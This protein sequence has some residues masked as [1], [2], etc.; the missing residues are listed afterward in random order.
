MLDHF[1]STSDRLIARLLH[2]TSILSPYGDKYYNSLL[3]ATLIPLT[4]GNSSI[5]QHMAI[6]TTLCSSFQDA[7]ST[8]SLSYNDSRGIKQH[9]ARDTT[10]CRSFHDAT[11]TPGFSYK[12][13]QRHQTPPGY[14]DNRLWTAAVSSRLSLSSFPGLQTHLVAK[15]CSL[16]GGKSNNL[17]IIG[18]T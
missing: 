7:A 15:N 9:M 17:N 8:P 14:P 12:W 2:S 1:F 6:V 3:Q 5:K 11:G 18:F 4:N 16:S 13:Q 10:L